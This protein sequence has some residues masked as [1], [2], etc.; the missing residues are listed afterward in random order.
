MSHKYTMRWPAVVAW[1]AAAAILLL[2]GGCG[3]VGLKGAARVDLSR[4][5]Q[6]V[7][8]L[9]NNSGNPD[10]NRESCAVLFT[11]ANVHLYV[12]RVEKR[13]AGSP[14]N[15]NLTYLRPYQT[16]DGSILFAPPGWYPTEYR[17]SSGEI[18]IDLPYETEQDMYLPGLLGF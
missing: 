6:H 4:T 14:A 5:Y 16:Q 11:D 17:A 13:G 9:P 18:R 1:V 10:C 12:P 7:Q 2:T 15:Y 3:V 8:V